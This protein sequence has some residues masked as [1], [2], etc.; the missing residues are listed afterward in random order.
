VRATISLLI[1]FL[2]AC[3]PGADAPDGRELYLAYGCAAC[4]GASGDGNGPAASLAAFRPRDLRALESYGGAKTKEGIA[5]TIAFG[6]ADGRTGMPAYPD[7]PKRERLAIA[8][9]I[10]SLEPAP[11]T[12][13]VTNAWAG[14]SNP[15]WKIAAAYLELVNGTSEPV[16]VTGVSSPAARVVEMHE[17]ATSADGVMSMKQ[18]ERIVVEPHQRVTLRPGG[19]HLMLIDLARDLRAGDT[20]EL[21][22]T[23]HDR[24]T[25]RV[26]ARVQQPPETIPSSLDPQPSAPGPAVGDLTL[27]D[28]KNRPFRFSSLKG[29]ALLFFGYT[30]CPDACPTVLSTIARAYREAGAGAQD[31]ET[32][33]VSVDPRDTPEVLDRYLRYFAA[34]P[35]RGLTGSKAEVDAVVR[36]FGAKYEIRDSGSAAG[37]VVDHT[38]KIYLVDRTG[39]IKK[40]FDPKIAPSELAKALVNS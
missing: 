18:V 8:D 30:Y 11:R 39:A 22:L 13:T 3:G 19:A 24:S 20:I 9:Y 26:T 32:L 15:A 25:R 37:P 1:L 21:N 17:T 4:H 35:A 6:I 2:A 5:A 23:F 28:H 12:V 27:T 38:L 16:A 29:P 7:I 34:V 36:R 10:L 33:F 31:V 14:E 40:S